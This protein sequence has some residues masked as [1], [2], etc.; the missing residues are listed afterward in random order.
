MGKMLEN[1]PIVDSLVEHNPFRGKKPPSIIRARHYK[2]TFTK[3]G[4]KA[5]SQGHWWKRKLIGDYVPA[6]DLEMLS[7]VYQQFGW[8]TG[9]EQ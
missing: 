2:Y 6:V 1:D 7:G 4:S 9:K 3:A 8:K 5:A